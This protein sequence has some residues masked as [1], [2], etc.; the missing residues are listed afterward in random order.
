MLDAIQKIVDVFES[1]QIPHCLIGGFAVSFYTQPR[2]TKDVD[3]MV[4]LSKE[5]TRRLT[6]RLRSEGI[7]FELRLADLHDPVGDVLKITI[8]DAVTKQNVAIDTI[9][10]KYIYHKA[11][12]ER[13]SI[14]RVLG[15]TIPV[16]KRED[17]ICLKLGAGSPKDLLDAVNIANDS[18]GKLNTA[19][20]EE[21]CEEMGLRRNILA[22]A[23]QYLANVGLIQANQKH[24]PGNSHK[25]IGVVD[26]KAWPHGYVRV[27]N[28]KTHL[29]DPKRINA[30]LCGW[31]TGTAVA[32]AQ[33][34][35]AE[36]LK[37]RE[38]FCDK[39]REKANKAGSRTT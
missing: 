18:K 5:D 32:R 12:I 26:I 36:V 20:I 21:T 35:Y 19:L 16:I 31:R 22:E 38:N 29:I 24:S 4:L 34:V 28:G 14:A 37:T 39:C 33:V 8:Q 11:M 13:S 1:E 23:K 10:S 9:V 25:K 15:R 3:F 17:L 7:R 30:C 2:A 6:E 27:S